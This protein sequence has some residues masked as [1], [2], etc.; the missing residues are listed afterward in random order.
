[1]DRL[2]PTLYQRPVGLDSSALL[3]SAVILNALLKSRPVSGGISV[4]NWE[5]NGG[6]CCFSYTSDSVV[7]TQL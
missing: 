5:I 6:I 3:F 7:L 4:N 2:Y 1:M